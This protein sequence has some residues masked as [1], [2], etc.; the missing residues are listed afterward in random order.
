LDRLLS[1]SIFRFFERI[2]HGVRIGRE[3]SGKIRTETEKS[4]HV[5]TAF[6][7]SLG[8]TETKTSTQSIACF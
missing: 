7:S 6:L 4:H 2:C 5:V 3:G 8:K 1:L